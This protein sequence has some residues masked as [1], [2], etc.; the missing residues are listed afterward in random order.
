MFLHAFTLERSHWDPPF[1]H[2][3][4]PKVTRGVWHRA[5]IEEGRLASLIA[6]MEEGPLIRRRATISVKINAHDT[7]LRQAWAR[8]GIDA[9]P[10]T[11]K[12]INVPHTHDL[13][14]SPMRNNHHL[15]QYRGHF[16]IQGVEEISGLADMRISNAGSFLRMALTRADSV[17]V[18]A[19]FRTYGG[20]TAY[21]VEEGDLVHVDTLDQTTH[22]LAPTSNG[23]AIW[24]E[25][26][27]TEIVELRL[28][29]HGRET[30][31][32]LGYSIHLNT[33]ERWLKPLESFLRRQYLW[34]LESPGLMTHQRMGIVTQN[35]QKA[36]RLHV[37]HR[38]A[39][40]ENLSALIHNHPAAVWVIISLWIERGTLAQNQWLSDVNSHNLSLHMLPTGRMLYTYAGRLNNSGMAP[41]P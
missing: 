39:S 15:Y 32:R 3:K 30:R 21:A 7:Y 9:T 24:I 14:Y 23:R 36:Y 6:S 41:H 31:L 13:L 5:L 40:H 38:V 33:V 20:I 28:H 18:T 4:A 11:V 2:R 34:L 8:V 29:G 22:M 16:C 25:N 26:K 27:S 37:R 35:V 17:L 12:P 1:Q 10:G 19:R